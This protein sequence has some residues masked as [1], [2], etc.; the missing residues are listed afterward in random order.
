LLDEIIIKCDL[1]SDELHIAVGK[2]NEYELRQKVTN[3][4]VKANAPSYFLLNIFW[5][6][7]LS[8]TLNISS[9]LRVNTTASDNSMVATG[10][11]IICK[12][13]WSEI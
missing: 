7:A 6:S 2:Y 10:L 5:P 4:D 12:S 9:L 1:A 3:L 11:T 13:G 8:V